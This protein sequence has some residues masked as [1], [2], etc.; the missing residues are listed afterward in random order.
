MNNNL[1]QEI[2]K[3]FFCK[4]CQRFYGSDFTIAYFNKKIRTTFWFQIQRLIFHHFTCVYAAE[5]NFGT[6][7]TST[8][9][10]EHGLSHIFIIIFEPLLEHELIFLNCGKRSVHATIF[11]Y[12]NLIFRIMSCRFDKVS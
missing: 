1:V 4:T 9:V 12:P 8:Y 5:T 7:K 2:L 3:I 11:T 6:N 10:Y